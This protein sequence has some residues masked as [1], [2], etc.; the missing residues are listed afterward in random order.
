MFVYVLN[1]KGEPLMPCKPAI[2]RL[3]LKEGKA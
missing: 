2:A 3:L 1:K